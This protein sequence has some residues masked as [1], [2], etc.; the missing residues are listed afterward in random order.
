MT[1]HSTWIRQ[2]RTLAYELP[3]L[4]DVWQISN[5]KTL[6]P[7]KKALKHAVTARLP[8]SALV[9]S[10]RKKKK[11]LVLTAHSVFCLLCWNAEV[12]TSIWLRVK[13][14]SPDPYYPNP[15]ADP[16]P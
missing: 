12:D 11:K 2:F 16:Y 8:K 3:R 1:L 14:Q 9:P 10:E 6:P 4:K 13:I 15:Q 5:I 7:S